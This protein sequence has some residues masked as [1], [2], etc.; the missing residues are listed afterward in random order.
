V[1]AAGPHSHEDRPNIGSAL[2]IEIRTAAI[3]IVIQWTS[4]AAAVY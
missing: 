3:S 1:L 2:R 4:R